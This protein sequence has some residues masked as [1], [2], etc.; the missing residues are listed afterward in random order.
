MFGRQLNQ[1]VGSKQGLSSG[2]QLWPP[3]YVIGIPTGDTDS[4]LS[5]IAKEKAKNTYLFI[6]IQIQYA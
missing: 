5:G 4:Y 1:A 6:N 3:W 2:P